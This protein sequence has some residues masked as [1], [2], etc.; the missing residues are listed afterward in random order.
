MMYNLERIA[1]SRNWK[2]TLNN[3]SVVFRR[4]LSWDVTTGY[5]NV[6]NISSL[7]FIS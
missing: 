4:P 3:P 5:K 6:L 1:F 2:R 7:Y